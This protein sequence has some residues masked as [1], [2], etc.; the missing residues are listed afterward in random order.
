MGLKEDDIHNSEGRISAKICT[1]AFCRDPQGLIRFKK[2][3][4]RISVIYTL[5]LKQMTTSD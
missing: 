2:Q 5:C 3:I 4:E 1:F